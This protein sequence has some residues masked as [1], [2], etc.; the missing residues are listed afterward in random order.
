M[1][2]WSAVSFLD[3]RESVRGGVLGLP[4]LGPVED[5]GLHAGAFSAVAVA[6]GDPR[7]RLALIERCR[8]AGLEI[9][10][11]V[12]PAAYV[13]RFASVG[14]GCV[15]FAQA[16]VN[17]DARLGTACIVNTGATIDHDCVLGEAVHVCP[18][19]HLAGSV[20]VGDRAW[21]GIGAVVRQ[22]ITIGHDAT[23]GAGA[24]VVADVPDGATVTGVPARQK[25]SEK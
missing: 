3:D 12:H 10:S 20:R 24:V 6:I 4:V 23:V 2:G 17:A 13:S 1:A 9:A 21:I 14:P 25:V 22:G 15:V 16:A 11:I 18:A 8:A 19:A 5:L 7:L